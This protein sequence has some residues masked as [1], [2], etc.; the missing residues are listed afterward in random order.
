MDVSE[1]LIVIKDQTKYN[2]ITCSNGRRDHAT[3][4]YKCSVFNVR[5]QRA[6]DIKDCKKYRKEN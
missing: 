6:D 2:C 4:N 3:D 1:E 5:V